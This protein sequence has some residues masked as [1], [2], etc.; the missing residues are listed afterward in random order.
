MEFAISVG[1]LRL[2]ENTDLCQAVYTKPVRQ[3][4]P[5]F[6]HVDLSLCSYYPSDV[7]YYPCEIKFKSIMNLSFQNLFQI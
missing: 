6:Q 4:E 1:S 3:V 7:F 2:V 5:A